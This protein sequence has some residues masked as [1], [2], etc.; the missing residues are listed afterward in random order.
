MPLIPFVQYM[1]PHGH[2][3]DTAIDRPQSVYDKAMKIIEAGYVFE[4]EVLTNG[5]VSLT[6]GGK[7]TDVCMELVQNGK[8]VPA[9]VDKM[10]NSF[11]FT[12]ASNLDRL[13]G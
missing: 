4:A 6:I 2:Q 11:N 9:A 12:L 10:I 3:V 8:E 1:R 13:R 7:H 5:M